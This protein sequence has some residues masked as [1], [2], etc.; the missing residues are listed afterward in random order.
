MIGSG[1]G[2]AARPQRSAGR[3]V[4]LAGLLVVAVATAFRAWQLQGAW[5]FYDDFYFIQRALDGPLTWT[6]LVEPYNGH[7]MP[8]GA[9]LTWLN[10]HADAMSF[11]YPAVQIIVGFALTGLAALRLV[12]RLFGVRWAALVPLVLFLF[13]PFLIPATIWWAAAVNQVPML[14]AVIMALSSFVAYLRSP[15]WP[16]L[17]ATFAWMAVGLLFVERTLT[18]FVVL[19]LVALLYFT[20]GTFPDRLRQLWNRYRAAVVLQVVAVLVY[21][22]AYAPFALNFDAGSVRSRPLFGVLRD[23]AGVAFPIG[24]AGG[25]LDW[26]V[27]G[28]TQSEVHPSQ[29]LLVLSWVVLGVVVLASGMTR[30]HGLRAWLIPVAGLLANAALIAVSRAIYFG[31]AIALDLRFQT[32]SALT[33]ALAAGLAFLPVPGARQSAEPRPG[34][35][36]SITRPSWVVGGLVGY[37]ALAVAS[38]ASY[39]LRNLTDTSP[40]RYY[41]NV[42]A[43]MAE[44]PDAVLLNRTVPDWL[45]APLAYPTN[46]YRHMFP[47]LSPG[48]QVATTVTDGGAVVDATGRFRPITFVPQR[49]QRAAVGADGCFA[50]ALTARTTH[51]LDGPVLGPDW[52]LRLRYAAARDTDAT[53]RIG[54]RTVDVRLE[55]GEHTL[56][57]PAPGAYASVDVRVA[58]GTACLERLEI[59]AVLPAG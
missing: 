13:S 14:L 24:A 57:T 15:R 44:D 7:L 23:L 22:A 27:S 21:L 46:T 8:A 50:R 42:A 19:W 58:S 55:R 48:P 25:P 43:S 59:G 39:P 33:V 9:L 16:A 38:T 6:Y 51:V 4:L 18:G 1:A 10:A 37:L 36:W 20:E 52:Y 29:L 47:M 49:T 5:F 28:V 26:Q 12:L 56:I 45:W 2:R 30:R 53:L 40:E 35:T 54:D 32:E 17:V 34:A 11:A 3:G 31:S 41:G